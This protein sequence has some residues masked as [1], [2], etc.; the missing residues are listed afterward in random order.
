MM[1]T[2]TAE[3]QIAKY[4]FTTLGAVAA[5]VLLVVS[6]AMHWRFGYSLGRSDFDGYIYGGASVAADAFKALAPFF[7]FAAWKNRQW[8]QAGAAAAVWLVTMTFA[9]TGAAGHAALNRMET[10]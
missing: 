5:L 10:T 9:L 4:V 8:V 3:R 7:F 2:A 1:P 6:M